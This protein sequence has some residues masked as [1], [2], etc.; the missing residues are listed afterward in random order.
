MQTKLWA[1][2]DITGSILGSK[3]L[4]DFFPQ[5]RT[6]LSEDQYDET[7][8]EIALGYK[9][10]PDLSAWLGY[11]SVLPGAVN[12]ENDGWEQLTWNIINNKKVVLISRSRVEER[13]ASGE[14][15]WAETLR[16]RILLTFPKFI[17]S[18]FAPV[19]SDELFVNLNRPSWVNRQRL[20][21]NRAYIGLRFPT[22]KKSTID[23]GYMNQYVFRNTV[24]QMYNIA[25][26]NFNITT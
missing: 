16:Q 11:T 5:T 8:T 4:Y 20:N 2:I 9:L 1:G 6:N 14:S 12:K 26:V 18:R 25:Y 13:K 15:E 17:F 24:N 21:Q 3:F 7:H 23:V 19:F 10:L 22:S